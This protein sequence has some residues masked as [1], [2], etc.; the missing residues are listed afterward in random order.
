MSPVRRLLLVFMSAHSH[1]T[2]FVVALRNALF[3]LAFRGRRNHKMPRL[4][5]A[6]ATGH[7]EL[8]RQGPENLDCAIARNCDLASCAVAAFRNCEP[9]YLLLRTRVIIFVMAELY[10]DMSIPYRIRKSAFLL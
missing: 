2:V 8:N 9:R 1:G 10:S 5:G 3:T 7:D 6:N 4:L